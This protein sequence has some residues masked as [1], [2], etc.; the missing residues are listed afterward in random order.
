MRAPEAACSARGCSRPAPTVH[1]LLLLQAHVQANGVT[2][3]QVSGLLDLSVQLLADNNYKVQMRACMLRMLVTAPSPCT[4]PHTHSNHSSAT[5]HAAP[6][7]MQVALKLLN[8][9]ESIA[10]TDRDV[11]RPYIK[12]LLPHVV[13]ACARAVC[14]YDAY[15]HFGCLPG[16]TGRLQSPCGSAAHFGC[17]L[18]SIEHAQQT[19]IL[20]VERLSDNRQEVRQAACNFMLELLQ[21]SAGTRCISSMTSSKCNAMLCRAVLCT[22][23]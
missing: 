8:C 13:S 15:A 14:A 20:Q 5:C 12:P 17:A 2:R 6:P 10:A 4:P 7:H 3:E 11:M 16:D 18:C 21:A 23:A 19:A 1:H 22:A 9:W